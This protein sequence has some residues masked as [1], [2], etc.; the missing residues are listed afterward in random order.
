MYQLEELDTWK[1][2]RDF[3][4]YISEVC[5]Q[6]PSSENFRLKDQSIRASRSISANIAEGFGRFHY[7]ENIQFSCQARGSLFECKEHMICAS[8]EK[9]IADEQLKEFE[10]K[11]TEL[12]KFLNGYI[13]YLKKQKSGTYE[14]NNPITH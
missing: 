7:Q 12:L 6:L 10:I 3:R 2:A 5:K 13:S 9:Y 1:K 8:D 4:M 11:F 14:P